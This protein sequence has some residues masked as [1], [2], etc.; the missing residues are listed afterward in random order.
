[1]DDRQLGQQLVAALPA[2]GVHDPE[3]VLAALHSLLPADDP[4]L[5]PLAAMARRPEFRSLASACQAN[6]Q[7]STPEEVLL[8]SL[9]DRHG[10]ELVT[11]LRAVLASVRDNQAAR[12]L[13]VGE[14]GGGRVADAPPISETTW[15]R[16]WESLHANPVATSATPAPPPDPRGESGTAAPKPSEAT[17]PFMQQQQGHQG[18]PVWGVVGAVAVVGALTA[19]GVIAL[20]ANRFCESLGLCSVAAINQAT[21]ALEAAEQTARRLNKAKTITAYEQDIRELDTQV[22]RREQDGVFSEAQ[23][24]SLKRLQQE[25]SLARARLE[26]EKDDLRTV[27]EVSAESRT[28]QDLPSLQAEKKRLALLQRLK[29]ISPQGFAL[30]DAQAL[31]ERLQPPPPR[32][33]PVPVLRRFD[34]PAATRELPT[35]DGRSRGH[36]TP[37]AASPS[38]DQGGS[39]APCREVP[40]W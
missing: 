4:R 21:A 35:Q 3:E 6:H 14:S 18:L 19:G 15:Q 28:L 8:R 22:R 12:S 9:G 27:R 30:E 13:Q 24:N 34:N 36:S 20:Q 33:T 5:E 25:L 7:S 32:F 10:P 26:K 23:R 38:P 40:L 29:D 1:M 2:G 16:Y 31:R 11:R 39:S 17:E 37:P